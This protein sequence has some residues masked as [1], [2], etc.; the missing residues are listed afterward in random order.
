[1]NLATKMQDKLNEVYWE[2]FDSDSKLKKAKANLAAFTCGAID[3]AVIMYPF[4]LA[5]LCYANWKTRKK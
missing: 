5:A 3:G 2:N 1:M 4:V